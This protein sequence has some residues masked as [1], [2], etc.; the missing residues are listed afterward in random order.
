M[1]A[2][3]CA[4]AHELCACL[5]PCIIYKP[6]HEFWIKI[7]STHYFSIY[8]ESMISYS[9]LELPQGDGHIKRDYLSLARHSLYAC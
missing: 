7:C 4:D 3:Q 6:L 5:G 2:L 8:L 1:A 9:L